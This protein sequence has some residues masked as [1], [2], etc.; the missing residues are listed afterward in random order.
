MGPRA[1]SCQSRCSRGCVA[2]E[3]RI[4]AQARLS[5]CQRHQDPEPRAE[6][7]EVP[8]TEGPG[9][10]DFFSSGQCP[11]G[12]IKQAG[13]DVILETKPRIVNHKTCEVTMLVEKGGLHVIEMWVKKVTKL[14]RWAVSPQHTDL[15]PLE[16]HAAPGEEARELEDREMG[17]DVARADEEELVNPEGTLESVSACSRSGRS[18]PWSIQWRSIW[19]RTF[20]KERRSTASVH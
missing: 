13:H 2:R 3:P 10:T 8:D 12:K 7:R 20:T 15:G 14:V 19:R 11:E 4:Q 16:G 17:S 6:G 5:S 9:P 18:W 1:M